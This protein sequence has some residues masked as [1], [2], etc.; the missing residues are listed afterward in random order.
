MVVAP[1]WMIAYTLAALIGQR[2][3]RPPSTDDGVTAAKLPIS[4]SCWS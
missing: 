2:A 1:L 4:L 3:H